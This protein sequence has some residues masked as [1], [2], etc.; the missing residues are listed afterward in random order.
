MA[1]AGADASNA[2]IAAA[3]MTNFRMIFLPRVFQV[4]QLQ[5]VYRPPGCMTLI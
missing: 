1:L 3:E 5:V 4:C 2:A